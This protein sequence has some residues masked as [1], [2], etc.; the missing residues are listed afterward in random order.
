M[1]D[2][3]KCNCNICRVEHH[4]SASL[5][6]PIRLA[7]FSELQPLYPSLAGFG[8]PSLVVEHLHS[9]REGEERPPTANEILAALIRSTWSVTA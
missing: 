5:S 2:N 1:R 7:R 8:S 3:L 4:L 9:Q 6:E